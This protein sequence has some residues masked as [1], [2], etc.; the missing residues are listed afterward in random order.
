MRDKCFRV[1]WIQPFTQ[2]LVVLA[3]FGMVSLGVVVSLKDAAS[4]R[5]PQA[6]ISA[7]SCADLLGDKPIK[8][9]ATP[10]RSELPVSSAKLA[11]YVALVAKPA[12]REDEPLA[13]SRLI[14]V[15]RLW[16]SVPSLPSWLD[17]DQRGVISRVAVGAPAFSPSWRGLDIAPMP[18]TLLYLIV[19]SAAAFADA[20]NTANLPPDVEAALRANAER[21]AGLEIRGYYQRKLLGSANET[22]KELGTLE[23]E[24]EFCQRVSFRLRLAGNRVH[25]ETKYPPSKFNPPDTTH[26]RSFDSQKLYVGSAHPTG[27]LSRGV[28][29]IHTP[30]TLTAEERQGRSYGAIFDLEYLHAAGYEGPQSS[31]ELGEPVHSLILDKIAHGHLLAAGPVNHDGRQM[32]EVKVRYPDPWIST[33]RSEVEKDPNLEFK[34]KESTELQQRVEKEARQMVGASRIA[35]FTLDPAMDFAIVRIEEARAE[36]GGLMF[37]TRNMDFV[38]AGSGLRLPET[39]EV[40]SYAYPTRPRFSTNAPAYT[41]TV[42]IDEIKRRDFAPEDFRVWFDLPGLAVSDYTHANARGGAPFAYRVPGDIR[43]VAQFRKHTILIGANVAIFVVLAALLAW[44]YT[45]RRAGGS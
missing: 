8:I 37:V 26:E 28:L 17:R 1:T 7:I 35:T 33:R 4:L 25:L 39:C 29:M 14:H 2:L 30:D 6:E 42:K 38:D 23:P 15:S 20:R 3:M 9:R 45:R 22:L 10:M 41:T 40:T 12:P 32:L 13:R 44:R 27:E 34:T 18:S 19:L 24:A 43:Q 36:G 5:E 11:E 21:L 16:P 31:S